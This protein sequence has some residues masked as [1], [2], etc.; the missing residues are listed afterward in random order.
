MRASKGNS[1]EASSVD[2]GSQLANHGTKYL[3]Y[4]I[5]CPINYNI[6]IIFLELK[7][8]AELLDPVAEQL[9]DSRKCGLRGPCTAPLGPYGPGGGCFLRLYCPLTTHV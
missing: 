4:Y 9:V 6:N 7:N 8:A 2:L 5:N 3:L 1:I